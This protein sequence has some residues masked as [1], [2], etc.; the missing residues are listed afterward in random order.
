MLLMQCTLRLPR[1]V[2]VSARCEAKHGHMLDLMRATCARAGTTSRWRWVGRSE[3]EEQGFLARAAKRGKAGRG[4]EMATLIVPGEEAAYAHFP[5]A[6]MFA[7]VVNS[8]WRAD[9][10]KSLLGTCGR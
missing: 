7:Q 5:N 8:R 6:M 1:F 9:H 4:S 10:G 3:D 2:F